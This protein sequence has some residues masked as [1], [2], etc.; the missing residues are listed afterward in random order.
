MAKRKTD[1]VDIALGRTAQPEQGKPQ[2][3]RERTSALGPMVPRSV[4]VTPEDLEELTTVLDDLHKDGVAITQSELW[5]FFLIHSLNEY[6]AGE[7]ELP[8]EPTGVK[9]L[10]Q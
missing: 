9:R 4:R 7:L 8:L 10:K 5:R 6:K 1:L 2:R 3:K